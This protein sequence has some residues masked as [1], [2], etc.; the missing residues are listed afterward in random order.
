MPEYFEARR[1]AVLTCKKRWRRALLY[2]AHF[3]QQGTPSKV[4]DERSRAKRAVTM[5]SGPE[6]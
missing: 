1:D 2:L 3:L 6:N 5:A 4:L